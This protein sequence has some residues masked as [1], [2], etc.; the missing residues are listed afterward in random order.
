MASLPTLNDVTETGAAEDR[1]LCAVLFNGRVGML[2]VT[3]LRGKLSPLQG[4][5]ASIFFFFFFFER[6]YMDACTGLCYY[7]L[8]GTLTSTP[9]VA[10]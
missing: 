7:F 9:V 2:S 4:Q 6:E 10:L 3:F 5:R 8:G 1:V